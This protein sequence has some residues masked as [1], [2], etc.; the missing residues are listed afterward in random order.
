MN[1]PLDY[2][3]CYSMACPQRFN[4]ARWLA[5]QHDMRRCVSREN[6]YHGNP[7]DL[8]ECDKFLA[9]EWFE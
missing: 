9:K 2:S 6:F 8:T 3:R 5:Y 7:H 4:C 1:L